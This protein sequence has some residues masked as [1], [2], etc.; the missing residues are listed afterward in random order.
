M[1]TLIAMIRSLLALG[2]FVT[3]LSAFIV[4]SIITFRRWSLRIAGPL[5]RFFGRSSFKIL[6]IDLSFKTELPFVDA[7][8]CVIIVNHQSTL[9]VLLAASICPNRVGAIGKKELIWV[10]FMNLAWWSMRLF[11]VDRSNHEAA[12]RTI[13][14]ATEN[15]LKYNRAV[16][17]APEGTR[18]KTGELLPFKKG[19]FHI[20]LQGK[21]PI[22]P[23]VFSGAAESMP[24][25][26]FWA[27]PTP[28]TAQFLPPIST[29]DWTRET[30]DQHIEAIHQDMN[31]AYLALRS[32][33]DLPLLPKQMSDQSNNS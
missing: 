11:L 32:E 2:F 21:L 8:P 27:Y 1:R 20:A 24:K 15:T 31:R 25:H 3:Y 29:D 28:I 10:P 4:F 5:L 7:G 19:A 30:L 33:M 16:M 14:A 12:V 6:G 23:V 26:T 22:Y 9:D 17:L 13:K 18:S